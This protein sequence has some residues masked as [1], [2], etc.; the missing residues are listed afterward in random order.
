MSRNDNLVIG[1]SGGVEEWRRGGGEEWRSGGVEEGRRG[2]KEQ[3]FT[4]SHSPTLPLPPLY[5][6]H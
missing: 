1:R 5:L 3:E 2:G 4:L 6:K